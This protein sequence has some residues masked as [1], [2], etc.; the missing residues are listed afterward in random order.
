MSALHSRIRLDVA[1]ST[2]VQDISDREAFSKSDAGRGGAVSLRANHF[3]GI[4]GQY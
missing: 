4:A 3:S 2:K 1:R